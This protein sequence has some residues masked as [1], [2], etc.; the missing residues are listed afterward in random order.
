MRFDARADRRLRRRPDGDHNV[1]D[2][3]DDELDASTHD[4]RE[5]AVEVLEDEGAPGTINPQTLPR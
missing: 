1:P 2:D 3:E 4:A 5:E